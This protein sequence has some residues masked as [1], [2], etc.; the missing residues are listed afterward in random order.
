MPTGY[1]NCI[2]SGISFKDFVMRCS[3]AMMSLITMREEPMDAP[4]PEEFEPSD[5][6][7]KK[8]EEYNNELKIVENYT[9]EEVN[10]EVKREYD[11]EIV[12]DREKINEAKE[13]KKKYEDMLEMVRKWQ[14]PTSEHYKFKSFMIQQLEDSIKWDCGTDYYKKEVVLLSGFEWKKN[15]LEE[16]NKDINRYI[17]EYK[18]EIDRTKFRNDWVKALRDS[19]K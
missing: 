14:P 4:I 8:L 10:E 2:K 1:T 15:K 3:R 18:E 19:L 16:L 5:Y 9:I 11:K 6:Y 12:Y 13:L 17:I 7:K